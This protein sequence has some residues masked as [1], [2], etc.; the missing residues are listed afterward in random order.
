ME[1][2]NVLRVDGE[3]IQFYFPLEEQKNQIQL[4]HE[5]NCKIRE[6]ES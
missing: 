4:L 3:R 1:G 6:Q 2:Q 5:S